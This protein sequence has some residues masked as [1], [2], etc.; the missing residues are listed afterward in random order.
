VPSSGGGSGASSLCRALATKPLS[1]RRASSRQKASRSASSSCVGM[2][3]LA[4]LYNARR[5]GKILVKE[6]DCSTLI[7]GIASQWTDL[8]FGSAKCD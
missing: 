1:M 8:W 6:D 3:R 2:P 5:V 4:S 7:R